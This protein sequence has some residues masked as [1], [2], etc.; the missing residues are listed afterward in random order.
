MKRMHFSLGRFRINVELAAQD[1]TM[2][3]LEHMNHELR[4]AH[5]EEERRSIL[6]RY[7]WV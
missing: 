7:Y 6:S 2:S 5:I 4:L 1:A 3:R